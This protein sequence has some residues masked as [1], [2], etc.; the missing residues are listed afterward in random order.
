MS[1]SIF[2]PTG[3]NSITGYTKNR[4]FGINVHIPN[5]NTE[6]MLILQEEKGVSPTLYV[7]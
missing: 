3:C 6:I 4:A 5:I 7:N 1:R 2:S